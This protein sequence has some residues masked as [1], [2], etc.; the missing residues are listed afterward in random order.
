MLTE[1][2]GAIIALVFVLGLIFLMTWGVRRFGLIPGASTA[3]KEERE[4]EVLDSKMLDARSRLVVVR[5][6]GKDYLLGNSPAGLRVIDS[7]DGDESSVQ[8]FQSYISE[9]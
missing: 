6:R 1:V 5:W 8:K 7:V 2:L 3:K 9:E 4:I